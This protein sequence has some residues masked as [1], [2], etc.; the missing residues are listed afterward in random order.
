MTYQ[1]NIPKRLVYG[2][3]QS[4]RRG[5]DLGIN[6]LH[7]SYKW[8][9]FSCPYC[10]D[11]L[12][13]YRSFDLPK[14]YPLPSA[15]EIIIAVESKLR[16]LCEN[17]SAL[18]SISFCGNGEP[19]L[20]PQIS[21]LVT[22]VMKLRDQYFPD[23]TVGIFS[24]GTTL[25]NSSVFDAMLKIDFRYMKLDAGTNNVFR[26]INQPLESTT[27]DSVVDN[28]ELLSRSVPI[29]IQSMFVNGFVDNTTP[30][31]IENWVKKLKIIQPVEIHIYSLDRK[32][33]NRN[34]TKVPRQELETIASMARSKYNL[35]VLDF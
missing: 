29:T 34:I 8:C 16:Y 18:D 2:P 32:P 10:Q 19:T 17:N 23:V 24:T 13:Q 21:H 3:I 6:P 14:D 20:H 28:L 4:R 25:G 9:P 26:A 22:E 33:V 15:D 30:E 27:L 1:K 11:G 7:S 5:N 35:P 12:S 31:E